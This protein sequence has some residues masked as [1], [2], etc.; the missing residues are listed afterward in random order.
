[1]EPHVVSCIQLLFINI[2]EKLYLFSLILLGNC[3]SQCYQMQAVT[4][5]HFPWFV[6]FAC[7][8]IILCDQSSPK[9]S[10]RAIT[11]AWLAYTDVYIHV[12]QHTSLEKIMQD[13]M[14]IMTGQNHIYLRKPFFCWLISSWFVSPLMLFIDSLIGTLAGSK[15]DI[16]PPHQYNRV[17]SSRRDSPDISPVFLLGCFHTWRLSKA[18]ANSS[19]STSMFALVLSTLQLDINS[20]N[21]TMSSLHKIYYVIFFCNES[22]NTFSKNLHNV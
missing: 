22:H 14:T 18:D 15:K 12:S 9:G 13:I 10:P 5:W 19:F 4:W 1:M 20:A 2:S 6:S 17:T 8:K 3:C 21:I 16:L 11:N 7:H